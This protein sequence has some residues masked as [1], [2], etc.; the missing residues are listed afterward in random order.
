VQLTERS[1]MSIHL[2]LYG[3]KS[4]TQY[5]GS[6]RWLLNFFW[7]HHWKTRSI[8]STCNLTR[9]LQSKVNANLFTCLCIITSRHMSDV[10]A[11]LHRFHITG[12]LRSLVF[13]PYGLSV[14]SCLFIII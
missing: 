10:D 4:K 1:F 8:S 11:R 9:A 5:E 12:A 7:S 6:D 3:T 2:S 14:S 13:T